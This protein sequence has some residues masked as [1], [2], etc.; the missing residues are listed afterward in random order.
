MNALKI[1]EL[2][3][4]RGC[5]YVLPSSDF[6]LGLT[7]GQGFGDTASVNVAKKHLGVT[8]KEIAKLCEK[9][10]RVLGKEPMGPRAIKEAVGDAVRSFGEE[11]KKRGITTTLPLALGLLQT[12]GD[13]RR[14]PVNGRLDQQRYGYVVWLP[15]P[16]TNLKPSSDDAFTKLAER[17]WS[18]I[19]AATVANFQWFSGLGVKAAKEAV[20][21]LKLVALDGTDLLMTRKDGDAYKSFKAPKDPHYV[22]TADLDS[23]VLLCRN[24]HSFIDPADLKR[25]VFGEKGAKPLAAFLDMPHHA[26]YDR[27]RLVGLWEYEVSTESIVWQSFIKPDAQMKKAVTEMEK[28]VQGL[29][30][31]RSFSLDSPESRQP[32]VD[33]LKK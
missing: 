24:M 8:D 33:S 31:A 26:I 10:F 14:V 19:G 22:L 23:V 3:S 20:A 21:P 16:L 18:W 12:R 7:V 2:P 4:A 28:F 15:S 9:V 17:Y 5:T 27:G 29:G 1:H 13:I 25:P 32:R 6:A 30:D 11:G